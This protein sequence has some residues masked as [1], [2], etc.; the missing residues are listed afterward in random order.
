MASTTKR[1]VRR[2]VSVIKFSP[3]M[4]VDKDNVTRAEFDAALELS[5]DLAEI[6]G[7]QLENQAVNVPDLGSRFEKNIPGTNQAGNSS[8]TMYEDE[9][10]DEYEQAMQK[11]QEGCVYIARK[12]DKPG[13]LSLDTWPVRVSAKSSAITTGNEPARTQYQYTIIDEPGLDGPVP[14]G[15][16]GAP[17]IT[18]FSP[19][20]VAIAGGDQVIV[21][22]V[23]FTGATAVSVGGTPVPSTDF[24]VV[25]ANKIALVSPAHAAGAVPVTVTT[26][27]GTSAAMNLTYA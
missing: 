6:S 18:S 15:T 22:G 27:A 8:I 9:D 21:S 13:S 11:D 16:G 23:G 17:T 24:A 4:P 10:G 26:P 7:F 1:F 25:T 5:D 3:V 14:A 12:G 19:S 2:G 20:S